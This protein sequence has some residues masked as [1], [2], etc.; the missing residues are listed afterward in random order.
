MEQQLA[1][2]AGLASG[3]LWGICSGPLPSYSHPSSIG[4]H[5]RF[6]S[7]SIHSQSDGESTAND[8]DFKEGAKEV[9]AAQGNHFL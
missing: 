3:I 9:A 4:T 1:W 6:S 5:L 7:S 8:M 2:L